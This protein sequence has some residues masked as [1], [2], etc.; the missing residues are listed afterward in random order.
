[1][2]GG[3]AH[4]FNNLLTVIEGYIELLKNKLGQEAGVGNYVTQMRKATEKAIALT[5]QLLTFSRRQIIQPK[6]ID[7][8]QVIKE[9]S[10]MLDRLIGEH[11]TLITNLNQEIGEIKAD[12]GQMEQV[13]MNLVVNARDAMPKGGELIIETDQINLDR[14]YNRFHP[15]IEPGDY[16]MISITDNG[17]GM[18]EEVLQRIF[19]PFFTTKEK[20]KGTGLGLATVYGIV[21]QNNGHIL[22]YSEVGKGTTFKIYFPAFKRRKNVAV[23]SNGQ[24]SNTGGGQQILV[25]EDEYLVRELICDTL[26]NLGYRVLEAANGEQAL[27]MCEHYAEQIDLVLTDLVMPVMNGRQLVER[28]NKKFP[29][30]RVLYMTGYDNNAITK[31]GMVIDD[32]EYISKPFSPQSLAKKLREVF[33]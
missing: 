24:T 13:L 5:R 33:G 22:V 20:G 27:K 3:I 15:D 25:V 23:E 11:I 1:L 29:N 26:R 21:K 32:I 2:A 6:M 14:S 18:N 10:K 30:M 31:Q 4:D 8:N 9:L 12:P 28:L 17:I 16:V 19:E 7:I